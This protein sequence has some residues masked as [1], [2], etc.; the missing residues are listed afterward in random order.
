ME[1]TLEREVQ[2]AARNK[3][4]LGV[5][6]LDIDHFKR[7][8]DTLGHAAGDV[9]FQELGALP[10]RQVRSSDIACRYGGDE[11]VLILPG[12]SV[13]ITMER[14]EHLRDNVKRLHVEYQ[15]R[16]LET[17]TIS[18]SV[19]VFPDHGSNG[20]LVL[21]SADAAL[22]RAKQEGRDRVVMAG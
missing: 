18:L 20:A 21:S 4:S 9:L 19:A 6:M 13:N 3:V 11:F 15:G 8:N 22:Y 2:R 10:S 1:E 17:V 16:V 5:I 14:A 12:A 7:L